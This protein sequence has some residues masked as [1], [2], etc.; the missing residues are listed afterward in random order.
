MKRKKKGG[1][2]T[3]FFLT[4]KGSELLS[5]IAYKM[6]ISMTAVLEILIR[7]KAEEENLDFDED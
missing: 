4:D 2:K 3:S 5:K 1:K 7:K 6:G